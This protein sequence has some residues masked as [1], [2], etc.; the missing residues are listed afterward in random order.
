MSKRL[1]NI[2]IC[3]LSI[4]SP[5]C[6]RNV[7]ESA[8]RYEG[9]YYAHAARA[10]QLK[11]PRV[12]IITF[13][14]KSD[15]FI[16]GFLQD[17]VR[18]TIFDE[19]ELILISAHS[20]GSEEAIIQEYCKRYPNIIYERFSSELGRYAAWNY[21]IKK[22]H[23][24]LI[25]NAYVEDRRNPQSLELQAR[26]LAEDK[27]I[28]L[29]YANVYLAYVPNETFQDNNCYWVMGPEE[30]RPERMCLCLPG[31]QPMWRTSLHIKH[32][33]FDESFTFAADFD[34]WNRVVSQGS[35]FK[36]LSFINGLFYQDPCDIPPHQ[37]PLR[38]AQRTNE[39]MRVRDTYG[40]LWRLSAQ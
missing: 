8:Y 31:P 12:S 39:D 15:E 4:F 2:F 16:E 11:K 5:L 38:A 36:K 7:Q 32:G 30:F 28:D 3:A 26:A 22:S 40:H 19:C 33:F 10:E 21:A 18:Q 13:L 9:V 23:A 25:T 35:R 29:V 14:Y 37:D 6:G 17:I 1:L 27:A 34:F 24:D 20:S